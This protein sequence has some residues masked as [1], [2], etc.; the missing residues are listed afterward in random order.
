MKYDRRRSEKSNVPLHKNQDTTSIEKFKVLSFQGFK[1]DKDSQ[2]A[3][4]VCFS[5][6]DLCSI[7]NALCLSSHSRYLSMA[8][9]CAALFSAHSFVSLVCF[10]SNSLCFLVAT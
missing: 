6:K 1:V 9:L 8:L 7:C 10:D 2:A 4:S 5:D 3:T